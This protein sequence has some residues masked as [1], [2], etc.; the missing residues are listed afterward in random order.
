[1]KE[2]R[3][4]IPDVTFGIADR[5]HIYEN[6]ADVLDYKFGVGRVTEAKNNI[7]L[8]CYVAGTFIQYPNLLEIDGHLVL[9][10][11]GDVTKHTFVRED[12]DTI[13]GEIECIV[14][15][16][17]DPFKK[18]NPED[19]DLCSKCAHRGR[20]PAINSLAAE[21]TQAL[22]VQLPSSFNPEAVTAPEDR[23][24]LL[25]MAKILEAWVPE[26]KKL[27]VK[28]VLEDGIQIP[29][30][31]LVS[32]KGNAKITGSAAV[33]EL[34]ERM[35]G[36]PLLDIVGTAKLSVTALTELVAERKALSKKDARGLLESVIGDWIE[37]GEDVV[38][39]K[40]DNATEREILLNPLGLSGGSLTE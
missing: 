23:A 10:R 1:M 13:L 5:I 20:C 30:Y 2:E 31:K 19:E 34:C 22:V 21:A 38:Y 6:L 36:I 40:K 17:N 15:S 3:V 18:P 9:P 37:N 4:E 35:L 11:Q 16:A 28:A 39:L 24:R 26:V 25:A 8:K 7:Q 32:R 29:H 14:N 27:Q 12:L 33:S